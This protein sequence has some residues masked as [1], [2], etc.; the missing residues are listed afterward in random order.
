MFGWI[1]LGIITYIG[2][3]V[4]AGGF[5]NPIKYMGLHEDTDTMLLLVILF[6]PVYLLGCVI[7]KIQDLLILAAKFVGKHVRR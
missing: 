6:W 3:G 5:Y 1:I 2:I 7:L 4:I